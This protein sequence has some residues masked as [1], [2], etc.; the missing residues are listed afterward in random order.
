[1]ALSALPS[2]LE[3][4]WTGHGLGVLPRCL[5]RGDA[6][7]LP[8][9][10]WLCTRA[11]SPAAASSR[12]YGRAV[13]SVR[14]LPSFDRPLVVA[15]T[16]C[17][18]AAR[19]A[20]LTPAALGVCL[21]Y[22]A[23]GAAGSAPPSCRLLAL[24]L[25]HTI[26]EPRDGGVYCKGAED[27]VEAFAGAFALL[28][29]YHAEGFKLVV[30]TNQGGIAKGTSDAAIVCSR[31][32]RVAA[33]IGA[34]VLFFVAPALDGYRKPLPS[35]ML[36]MAARFNG[37]VEV[38]PAQ[39]LYVGDAAGRVGG[40]R[41]DHS[42]S[43]LEF[44]INCGLGFVTGEAF[45]LGSSARSDARPVEAVGLHVR[46][47]SAPLH[48]QLPS[49]SPLSSSS[50]TSSSSTLSSSSLPSSSP[51]A[52][53]HGVSVATVP[54]LFLPPP[55]R[56]G[57]V[58]WLAAG[59]PLSVEAAAGVSAAEPRPFEVLMLVAPPGAGKSSIARLLATTHM[60]INQDELKTKAKCLAAASELLAA[61]AS[62]PSPSGSGRPSAV[63]VDA[64]NIDVATRA[65]WIALA[66]K[67]GAGVRALELV[68]SAYEPDAAAALRRLRLQALH[69]DHSRGLGLYV[70]A[71]EERRRVGA[72]VVHKV[73]SGFQAVDAVKEGLDSVL[74]ASLAP[75]PFCEQD[76]DAGAPCRACALVQSLLYCVTWRK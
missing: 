56:R 35:M 42:A 50:S 60:R 33:A 13:L 4:G 64:C 59:Q 1:M 52:V 12:V 53:V 28:R 22:S 45:F 24:D 15:P 66:R 51:A 25:D 61:A 46:A 48:S 69:L 7:A 41:K 9:N 57:V 68:G 2:P 73:A 75:G 23:C 34:P 54:A 6:E 76:G 26:I 14:T 55:G 47:L 3:G 31:C 72:F 39:S 74:R 21:I 71:G 40:G 5:L 62:S 30:F 65:D 36:L 37:G 19:A 17:P 18:S 58:G 44:A 32:V 20:A 27:F 8:D 38:D 29:R 49:P 63:V 70:G 43:D 16:A 10:E 11:E 67:H